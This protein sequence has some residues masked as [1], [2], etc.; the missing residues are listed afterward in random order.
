[1]SL[2]DRESRAALS[3]DLRHVRYVTLEAS[4]PDRTPHDTPLLP[5]MVRGALLGAFAFG[6]LALQ[7]TGRPL[8]GATIGSAVGAA[9]P[10]L[11]RIRHHFKGQ[12]F[13]LVPWGVLVDRDHNLTAIRWSGVHA[14]DVRYRA[15][16]DGSVHAC[17]EVDSVVGSFVG[18]ASDA[19]DLGALDVDLPAVAAASSCP[20][21]IDLDGTEGLYD[22]EP[23]VGR[24]LDAARNILIAKGDE[25]LGLEP[26]SYRSASLV[27]NASPTAEETV[28]RTLHDIGSDIEKRGGG[29]NAWALIA[30]IAGELRLRAFGSHLARL[31]NAPHPAVA[32][33][34][35]AALG[36]VTAAIACDRPTSELLDLETDDGDALSWFISPDDFACLKHWRNAPV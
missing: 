29:A 3:P 12:G 26:C 9:S 32:A 14:L 13:A 5:S 24:L 18:F 10:L 19:V 30:A 4:P 25:R 21:A 15:S 35:R 1:M 34:A 22:G 2:R 31:A 16:S 36:R 11:R 23:F 33:F 6:S 27:T 17:I 28:A 7:V 20:L 8:A